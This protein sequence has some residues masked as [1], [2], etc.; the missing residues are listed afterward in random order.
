MDVSKE[1]ELTPEDISVVREYMT[2]FPQ[3]LSGLPPDRDIVLSIELIP[4]RSPELH[5]D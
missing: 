4:P 3:D 5:T 1:E 2:V